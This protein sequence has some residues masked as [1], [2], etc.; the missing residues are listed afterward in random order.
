MFLY[1]RSL[2][3]TVGLQMCVLESKEFPIN[4]M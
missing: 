3:D 2:V 4:A 1:F